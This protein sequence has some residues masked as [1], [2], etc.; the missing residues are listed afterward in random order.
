MISIRSWWRKNFLGAEGMLALVA[1]GAFTVWVERY[2]G[3]V[4]LEKLLENNRAAIYGAL[5]SIFGSLLGFVIATV[6]IVVAFHGLPHLRLVRQS[7]TYPVLW[8]VF[9]SAVRWLGAAT[10][11][12]LLALVLDHGDFIGR[13]SLYTC[14][15]T[16]LVA[17]LRVGRCVWVMEKLIGIVVKRDAA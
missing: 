10:V 12:A 2:D 11:A 13:L 9:T 3:F 7:A 14:I 4:V 5:A 6:S 1:T 15:G 8:R 17:T 16:T